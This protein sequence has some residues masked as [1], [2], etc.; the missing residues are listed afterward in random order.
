MENNVYGFIKGLPATQGS[1]T[2]DPGAA[3]LIDQVVTG[4]SS[5]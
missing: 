2:T 4:G 5:I 3:A 1:K